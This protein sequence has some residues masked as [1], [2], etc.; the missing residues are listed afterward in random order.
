M[1]IAAS[2]LA[3]RA[4]EH[5]A[6]NSMH[7]PILSTYVN[8]VILRYENASSMMS[9]CWLRPLKLNAA[10]KALLF[11]MPIWSDSNKKNALNANAL[12]IKLQFSI[13]IS[14]GRRKNVI[15][16]KCASQ[17]SDSIVHEKFLRSFFPS[18]RSIFVRSS[19]LLLLCVEMCAMFRR[20]RLDANSFV[21]W[22]FL[23]ASYFSFSSDAS[24]RSERIE[25]FYYF[26]SIFLYVLMQI[27]LRTH[28]YKFCGGRNQMYNFI[29]DKNCEKWNGNRNHFIA[30]SG[31][32]REIASR[33]ECIWIP[34]RLTGEHVT[35]E[36]AFSS[37]KGLLASFS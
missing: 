29:D 26:S 23:F 8:N 6:V 3:V 22:I 21:Y 7:S 9:M 31:E 15:E 25:T 5:I 4:L 1:I 14:A 36:R 34:V 11:S 33:T 2:R 37:I 24:Q 28:R 16:T 32:N 27:C 20:I 12:T 13:C 17:S 19:H 18:A 35:W 10:Q 30:G